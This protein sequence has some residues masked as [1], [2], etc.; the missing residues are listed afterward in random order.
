MK[1]SELITDMRLKAH[2]D[3]LRANA[4]AFRRFQV[5]VGKALSRTHK[6]ET[7]EGENFDKKAKAENSLSTRLALSNKERYQLRQ[8]SRAAHLLRMFLRGKSYNQVEQKTKDNTMSAA[9]VVID[10]YPAIVYEESPYD[11]SERLEKWVLN[12][13]N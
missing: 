5:K 6:Y 8:E 1:T 7:K 4:V 12:S 2:L 11:L 10:F 9:K 3:G 13:K